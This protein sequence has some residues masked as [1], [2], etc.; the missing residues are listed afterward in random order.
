MS[1]FNDIS[2]THRIYFE[3]IAQAA[4]DS[5]V[6]A[7]IIGGYVRDLYLRRPCKDIDIVCLGDGVALAKNTAKRLAGASTVSTFQ[8]FGTAMFVVGETEIEFVGARRESYSPD[9]RKPSVAVGTLTDDQN[10][11][12]FTINALAISLNEDDYGTLLDPFGGI[13]DLQNGI[14]RTPMPNPDITFSDDPLRMLRAIRFATQLGFQIHPDTL[15][16]ISSNKQRIE[17][18]SAERVATEL[19]KMMQTPKPSIGYKLLFHTGLLHLILPELA[20]MQ[21]VEA[22]NGIAHKDNFYHTLQVLDNICPST[23]NLWLRWAALLHDIGKPPTK[24][25]KDGEGWTFHGHEVVGAAITEKIFKR[26]KLPL[27]ETMRFVQKMVAMHQRPVMLTKSEI[28]DSAL[29]RLLFDAGEDI[30][31]LMLLCC[32]DI[33]SRN[34]ERVKRYL[35]NYALLVEKMQELEAKDHL[36][37]WQPPISGEVI[38]QVFGLRPSREVGIIKTAIREAIL[39]GDIPNEYEVAYTYM[40]EQGQR[41]GM[42]VVL[43]K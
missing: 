43:A 42:S 22:R 18:I 32:A 39:E 34:E 13:D 31:E 15:E 36:R 27:N 37:N 1:P 29:R 35:H 11:R 24:R 38:M 3:T 16:A 33:T 41:L 9:S 20:A 12:D 10:R 8:H 19:N 4:R 6:K 40:L 21:G 23:N 25:F 30:D 14:I 7:Y 26:L 17:I 2:H 28:S 5:S